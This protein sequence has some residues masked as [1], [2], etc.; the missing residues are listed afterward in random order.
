MRLLFI[1]NAMDPNLRR[2]SRIPM[3]AI[4]IEPGFFCSFV[5]QFFETW[6]PAIL[7]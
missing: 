4:A 5:R 6:E 1:Y 2:S 7:V 3:C